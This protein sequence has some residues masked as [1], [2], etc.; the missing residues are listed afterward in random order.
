RGGAADAAPV[1]AVA[2]GI[3]LV[4]HAAQIA[5]DRGRRVGG[6]AEPLQLR[7]VRVAARRPGEHRLREQ[8]FA[9][10]RGEALPIQVA[11]MQRPEPHAG[12]RPW[13]TV[14]TPW[15]IS[16]ITPGGCRSAK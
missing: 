7:M 5:A 1:E 9:P 12:I 2:A 8:G 16:R 4:R 15:S 11:R 3:G 13:K 10:A 6:G 14:S